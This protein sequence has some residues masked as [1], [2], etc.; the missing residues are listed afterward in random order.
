MYIGIRWPVISSSSLQLSRGFYAIF[1]FPFPFSTTFTLCVPLMPLSLNGARHSF[2]WGG[3]VWQ[4]LPL[5]QLHPPL[6]PL[7][8][9]EVWP[10]M[11]SWRSFSAWMLTHDT[12]STKLYQVT[13]VSTVLLD[14]RFALVALWSLPLFLPRHP[15]TMMTPTTMMMIRMEMLALPTLTRCLLDTLT[16]CHSWQKG[17]V[18]LVMRVVIIKE[19]VHWGM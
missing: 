17:E 8:L 5:L 11:R 4:L 12:L 2:V 7:L 18:V 15:R 1:L 9:W 16:L 19:C 10:L 6:L 13:P 14:G 3:P